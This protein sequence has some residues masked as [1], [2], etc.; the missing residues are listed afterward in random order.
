MKIAQI[1]RKAN[2]AHFLRLPH[3]D[4]QTDFRRSIMNMRLTYA[5]LLVLSLT[6]LGGCGG[7]GGS[8]A[9]TGT[10]SMD[11]ADAKPFIG[12]AQP[13]ELWVIFDDVQVHTS[14]GGW[15]S[16]GL[17]ETP[18]EINLLAFSDGLKTELAV[19]TQV[20]AGHVTQ[21][22]FEISRAYMVFPNAVEE[23]DLDVPSGTLKTDKQIDWTLENGGA[24]SLTV[25]FDLSQSVVQSGLG[26]KLKP[27]LHLFNNSPEEAATIC[28][29]ITADSFGDP[30]E[31]VVSVTRNEVEV[32]EP[33]TVVTVEKDL[34]AATTGFCIYWL[35]PLDEGGAYHIQIDNGAGVYEEDVTPLEPGEA[36]DLNTGAPISI[37]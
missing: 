29:S 25:H 7:G 37:L 3:H 4:K 32:S 35:V 9:G 18:F 31:V 13:D 11:V 26:Y 5:L 19:P 23:I 33:Y 22:R 6:L 27:V 36:F 21:I 10:V 24:M 2:L 30:P 20:P 14:G 34:E 17:P 1:A 8:G 15:V 12:G 28:G 16:L